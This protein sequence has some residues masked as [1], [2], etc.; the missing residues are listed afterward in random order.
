MIFFKFKNLKTKLRASFLLSIFLISAC[1]KKES[2]RP[3]TEL[4]SRGKA[5][6]MSNCIACH[7]SDPRLAGSVGPDVAYSSLELISSRVLN[8]PYP[9]GYVPKR[10]AGLMPALPFLEKDI[11]ALHAYLNSF[12]K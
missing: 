7:N 10:Q 5:S 3:L 9:K 1:A 12:K 4:E 11:P 8:K 2:E 6:Y